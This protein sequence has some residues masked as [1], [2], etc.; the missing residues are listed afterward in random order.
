[1]PLVDHKLIIDPQTRPIVHTNV[2]AI[3]SAFKIQVPGP[4]GREVVHREVESRTAHTPL[5]IHLPVIP[6]HRRLPLQVWIRKICPSPLRNHRL[7][8]WGGERRRRRSRHTRLGRGHD[9]NR[10]TG[11]SHRR[12]LCWCRH[13]RRRHQ[14][15]RRSG[16]HPRSL[17]PGH[18]LHKIS[19]QPAGI[20]GIDKGHAELP[21]AV[22]NSTRV[23][24]MF[25]GLSGLILQPDENDITSSP[26]LTVHRKL[27]T[28]IAFRRRQ[29]NM[30]ARHRTA[31]RRG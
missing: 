27:C 11:R 2:K 24:V 9:G 19:F 20:I 4:L 12:I 5:E 30:S 17:S 8:R 22:G 29:L 10:R 14:A 23:R 18:H 25:I 6:D 28:R 7:R 13:D 31:G 16:L 26:V 3:I 15:K 21:R 1:M